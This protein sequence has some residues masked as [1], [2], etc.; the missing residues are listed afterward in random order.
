MSEPLVDAA[1]RG[2]L[3]DVRR[4]VE[5][6][7]DVNE[8]DKYWRR[9]LLQAAAGGHLDTVRYLVEQGADVNAADR[10]GRTALLAAADGGHLGTVRYLVEQGPSDIMSAFVSA[11][12][13]R[14][15]P[16]VMRLLLKH[17]SKHIS[18]APFTLTGGRSKPT[19]SPPELAISL[20]QFMESDDDV[21]DSWGTRNIEALIDAAAKGKLEDVRR[22]AD[23]V[24][25]NDKDTYGRRA[26]LM[27]A[28]HGHID[29]VRWLVEHD[30]RVDSSD[31][32]GETALLWAAGAGH[33]EIVRYLVQ[34]CADV[35]KTNICG[36]TALSAAADGGHLDI[37]RYLIEHRPSDVDSAYEVACT[38]G[39]QGILRLLMPHLSTASPFATASK[40][41]YQ[42]TKLSW[43][44]SVS[45]STQADI[46]SAPSSSSQV[47][48]EWAIS[49]FEVATKQYHETGTIGGDF[50]AMWLDADVVLKLFVPQ[51]SDAPFDEEVCRWHQMRH[52]NVIK[53]YGACDI[54]HRFFVCEH[55]SNGSVV[56][57][58]SRCD[59]EDQTPWKYL[60]EAAL[61]LAYL[62]E[63]GIAHGSLRGSSI[64]IGSDGLAKL[65]DFGVRKA[66]G[67]KDTPGLTRWQSPE[68]LD[69]SMR[70]AKTPFASDIYALG[71][72]AVEVVTRSLPWA[73]KDISTIKSDKR[74]WRP[75]QGSEAT[76]ARGSHAPA[77]LSSDLLEVVR[78]TS[79]YNP[80]LRLSASGCVQLFERLA[81]KENAVIQRAPP[82]GELEVTLSEYSNGKLLK[83]WEKFQD[84]DSVP[85]KCLTIMRDLELIFARL[86]EFP[87]QQKVFEN[88]DRLFCDARKVMTA[89]PLANP[90]V[91]LSATRATVESVYAFQQRV[92]AFKRQ[93]GA[94]VNA[95]TGHEVDNQSREKAD[96]LQG[97]LFEGG[98]LFVSEISDTWVV[99][100]KL[101]TSEERLA[102][103]ACL[104]V[105]INKH[106][107]KYKPGQLKLMRQAYA[108]I[109]R[110]APSE[111]SRRDAPKS[112]LAANVVWTTPVWFVPWYELYV[113]EL[114]TIGDGGYG[115]VHRARWLDTQVV[116][117]RIKY[118]TGGS[119]TSAGSE[120]SSRSRYKSAFASVE[121]DLY[122]NPEV[123][124]AEAREMFMREADIWFKLGHPNVVR[125][126]GACHV[127]QP[128]F[129]C[130]YAPHGS[131]DKYLLKHPD[132][133]WQKLHEAALGLL[134][135]H[136]R[137][138]VHC[139]FKCNNIVVGSDY[140][141][142]VTDF[143]LSSAA[144]ASGDDTNGGHITG[145]WNWLA[146]ELLL[147][148]S[149]QPT[150]ES[151]VFSFAM[152]IV[153]A[154]R[155]VE[156]ARFEDEARPRAPWLDQVKEVVKYYLRR[157]QL[158][159]RP[160]SCTDAQWALVEKMARFK[161]ADRIQMCTVVDGLAV[162]AN[163]A[164]GVDPMIEAAPTVLGHA[165]LAR[166]TL[167]LRK[168]L[169]QSV[170]HIR[171][172]LRYGA[173]ICE[174]LWRRL[175]DIEQR[176]TGDTQ[177][178]RRLEALTVEAKVLTT[179]MTT[180]RDTLV[181]SAEMALRGYGL[182]RRLDK[183]M[184]AEFISV[185]AD[186]DA[187]GDA[188]LHDWKRRC[189]E[190]LGIDKSVTAQ[191]LR[192]SD[193]AGCEA[194]LA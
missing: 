158:P 179:E 74:R 41:G 30:A 131:L 101:R 62:H 85:K 75:E 23:R 163:V 51:T 171:R 168:E 186:T 84:Q 64:L 60:H 42:D 77:E 114:D 135:L 94:D 80:S 187:H 83:Q 153:E 147:E 139:D 49:P 188:S 26:L 192:S 89:D 53:L 3:E 15:H 144:S 43:I 8:R 66:P 69:A 143:G 76:P 166:S 191:L 33:L 39:Y 178:T 151:D 11:C 17:T 82:A 162:L 146:P 22:I 35:N 97:L 152:C 50:L 19:S 119:K 1:S 13:T 45:S 118:P 172:G 21:F 129:V 24:G 56:E 32:F 79:C 28:C 99:L 68:Q 6:G 145:A 47:I 111:S 127:G 173:D 167:K 9:A 164:G 104:D 141:A 93:L 73:N 103:L 12:S 100:Q 27:A 150:R 70:S 134:Y 132:E 105:E 142:K 136:E 125:L 112:K 160:S 90:V 109:K 7:A 25:V 38:R 110:S 126:F 165:A 116:V 181:Q 52:P 137:G 63:R 61:G 177:A 37:V 65:A 95:S 87:H 54:G 175:E 176:G 180:C 183:F 106:S 91:Q 34:H 122:E 55:A 20:E 133:I 148:Q 44:K 18:T 156:A 88:A 140:K 4:L 128:F 138:I 182:H 96:E 113:N 123:A 71:I 14:R 190:L 107:D 159:A 86:D 121:A 78:R 108:D 169:T 157:H 98:E 57:Y 59:P 16:D 72:C 81:E 170:M 102:F 120:T 46:V 29:V 154:L 124:R 155:V 130:E 5:Q 2:R 117:K 92:N 58:L 36:E 40:R 174:L 184:A 31:E 193:I 48:P 189:C 115:T 149:K 185:V 161:P 10:S 194:R 67:F